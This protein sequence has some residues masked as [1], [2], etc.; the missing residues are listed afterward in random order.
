LKIFSQRLAGFLTKKNV[1]P[2]LFI[3]IYI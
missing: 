2:L 3:C 1:L